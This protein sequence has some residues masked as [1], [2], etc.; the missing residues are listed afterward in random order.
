MSRWPERGGGLLD[1][2]FDRG[3]VGGVGHDR[4]DAA[5][6]GARPARPRSPSSVVGRARDDRDVDALSGELARDGLAD[7][8]A[9]AGDDGGFAS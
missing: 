5:A 6:G 8:P 1:H 7:T 4:H 2:G 3:V 9:A